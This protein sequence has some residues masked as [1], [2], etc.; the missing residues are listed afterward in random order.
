VST[1]SKIMT[2]ETKNPS[3]LTIEKLDKVLT[4]EEMRFRVEA[5]RAAIEAYILK[6]QDEDF[7]EQ[8]DH[9]SN[10]APHNRELLTVDVFRELDEDRNCE[11]LDGYLIFNNAPN[12]RHQEIVQYIGGVIDQYIKDHHDNCRMFNVGVNVRLGERDDTVLIPDIAVVCEPDILDEYGINGAP[13]WVIEVVS[14]SSRKRD[15]NDK[16]HKYM[17][18]GVKEYWIID[19]DR[20]MVTTYIAG[21]PMMAYTYHFEDD[22][23][24]LIYDKQLIIE[25]KSYKI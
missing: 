6:H 21:E 5:Y 4:R 2:G 3:Y 24:V 15:Y 19:P 8:S 23:P 11:L 17:L 18:S 25:L 12:L 1:V 22:I 13:D 14:D 9:K 10:L 16:M 7:D 20:S